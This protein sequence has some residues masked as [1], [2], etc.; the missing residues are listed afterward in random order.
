MGMVDYVKDREQ[1]SNILCKSDDILILDYEV[2]GVSCAMFLVDGMSDKEQLDRNVIQRLKQLEKL[3]KPFLETLNNVT[4]LADP[5]TLAD[6]L[7]ELASKVTDG[8]IALILD[9]ADTYYVMSLRNYKTR[10][11]TEPPVSTV[12]RGPREGFVEDMKTN[13]TQLRRRLRTPK[14]V[15]EYMK[16][17]KYTETNLAICYIDGVADENNINK[18]RER[19]SKIDIDGIIDSAYIARFIEDNKNSMFSQSGSTEKPDIAAAKMLEGRIAIIVDGSPTVLTVPFV[20]FEHFQ[21]SEDYYVRSFRATF[22]RIIRVVAMIIAITLPAAYVALQ[23]FQYQMFPLKLLIVIMNSLYGVPLTPTLEMILLL[24][25]FEVLHEASIRMPRYVGTALS[26]VGAIVLGE[27]AV[28]A[29]L[30]STPSVLVTALSTIG[31]YGVP[32]EVDSASVFRIFFVAVAGV[33]GLFGLLLGIIALLIYLVSLK[34]YGSSYLTPFAP[35][36]PG[37]FKDGIIK[38]SLREMNK[39]PYSIPTKN[40][41][42]LKDG[43]E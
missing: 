23:E 22:V 5:I 15:F 40:R 31:L 42:R 24:L 13:M 6:N 18:V 14:L 2:A 25:L 1:L 39:R 37:D 20:L 11:I 21:S 3:E 43:E 4:F 16:V 8:D 36:I 29:G 32:E 19:I 27:A 38:S 10:A 7:E 34:S 9:G 12:I 35:L 41:T 28:N 17:G 26:I 30:L 33:L